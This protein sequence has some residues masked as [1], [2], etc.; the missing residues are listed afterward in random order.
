MHVIFGALVWLHR[1]H[2]LFSKSFLHFAAVFPKLSQYSHWDHLMHKEPHMMW[3]L[4]LFEPEI[5]AVTLGFLASTH[6]CR[7]SFFLKYCQHIFK[8][9]SKYFQNIFT[10]DSLAPTDDRRFSFFPKYCNTEKC[11]QLYKVNVNCKYIKLRLN[12]NTFVCKKITK[13]KKFDQTQE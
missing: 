1:H 11:S 12:L 7:F 6:D 4:T 9:L 2:K 5:D 13:F 3:W 8:I 10:S